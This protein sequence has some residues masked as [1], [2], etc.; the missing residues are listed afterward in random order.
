MTSVLIVLIMVCLVWAVTAS[1]MIAAYLQKRGV[2]IRGLLLRVMTLDFI[3]EYRRLTVQ[4][5]G[6]AGTL[7]NH[8]IGAIIAAMLLAGALLIMKVFGVG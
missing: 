8:Y 6:R 1:L 5:R 2:W 4:E 7:F 3:D